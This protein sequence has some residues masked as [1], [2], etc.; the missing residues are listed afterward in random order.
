MRHCLC[1]CQ[2]SNELLDS[3][4]VSILKPVTMVMVL[5]Y[6]SN[7][8]V[9]TKAFAHNIQ[10]LCFMEGYM[11]M[12][13]WHLVISTG[14]FSTLRPPSPCTPDRLFWTSSSSRG[15]LSDNTPWTWSDREGS[16]WRRCSKTPHQMLLRMLTPHRDIH[17]K[18]KC[19][20]STYII[21]LSA[22]YQHTLQ[23]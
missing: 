1:L 13:N 6:T 14:A 21:S 23:V 2:R 16:L 9:F 4:C 3:P 15:R 12:V 8:E 17:H 7:F 5:R 11:Y 22:T 20:I 10:V 18:F 19:N